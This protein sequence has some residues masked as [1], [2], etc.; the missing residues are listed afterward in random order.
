[1]DTHGVTIVDSNSHDLDPH[2]RRCALRRSRGLSSEPPPEIVERALVRIGDED[3]IDLQ[4]IVSTGVKIS[5]GA[6]VATGAV[7]TRAVPQRTVVPGNPAR[8]V[9]ALG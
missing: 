1:M 9:K 6:I 8:D 7:M 2:R 5:A 3:W 4:A